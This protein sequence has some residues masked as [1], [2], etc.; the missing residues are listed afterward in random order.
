MPHHK[1]TGSSSAIVLDMLHS[2]KPS[3]GLASSSTRSSAAAAPGMDGWIP[4]DQQPQK[5]PNTPSAAG[6][7]AH[8]DNPFQWQ[9]QK[10]ASD[11][12]RKRLVVRTLVATLLAALLL[13]LVT[14]PSKT[15][16]DVKSYASSR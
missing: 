1:S 3:T 5:S 14:R 7:Y 2:R 9:I 10:E 6:D 4:L 11:R 13:W 15:A 16:K 8:Q 12:R